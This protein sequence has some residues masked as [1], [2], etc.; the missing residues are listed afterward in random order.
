[1]SSPDEIPIDWRS[2]QAG[3]P[4][5]NRYVLVGPPEVV[6]V[7]R[8]GL[9]LV[10]KQDLEQVEKQIRQDLER[11]EKRIEV[12]FGPRA[13]YLQN[14]VGTLFGAATGIAC[15]IPQLMTASFLSNWVVPIF[16]VSAIALGLI[17]LI[18][19]LIDRNLRAMRKK[20]AIT[21]TAEIRDLLA[22]GSHYHVK[23]ADDGSLV[24]GSCDGNQIAD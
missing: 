2:N 23:P 19:F 15:A 14:L 7:P 1:M 16:T 3:L 6:L 18:L 5:G 13:D 9:V 22:K 20:N 11:I 10:R 12:E 24:N 4:T 8:Q 17:S 21:I